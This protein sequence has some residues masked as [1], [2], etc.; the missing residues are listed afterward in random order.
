MKKYLI[1]ID[2]DGTLLNDSS[3][4]SDLSKKYLKT[5]K[6]DGHKIVIATGRPYR[7]TKHFYDQLELDT[8]LIVNN[9][10]TV[11]RE[12]SNSFKSF[13]VTIP[14]KT[15]NDVFNFAKKH[16]V[17][18]FYNI[19]DDLYV[20]NYSEELKFYYFINENTTIYEDD[21]D[22]PNFP[23]TP[24]LVM[25]IKL[26]FSNQF[27]KY[28]SKSN[29]VGFRYWYKDDEIVI[30]EIFPKNYNKGYAFNLVRN[31]YNIP[32]ENTISF[33]DGSNDIELLKES[34]HGVKMINGTKRLLEVS[35]DITTFTNNEDGVIKYLKNFI[36]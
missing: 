20:Y 10:A 28:L 30:Y 4:I 17:S 34:G 33:G 14:K 29:T 3:E 32:L 21:F 36:K 22:N 27:E 1:T 13:E 11:Y 6:D 25:T 19:K 24:N 26:S 31:Y 15:L 12:N 16:L 35:D 18:S 5:L 2:L 9:G 23:E 7:G 8:P